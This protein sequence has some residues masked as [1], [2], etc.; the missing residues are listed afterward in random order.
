MCPDVCFFPKGKKNTED[1]SYLQRDFWEKSNTWLQGNT[2]L[3]SSYQWC[4]GLCTSGG[5]LVISTDTISWLTM[6]ANSV[7]Q[8]FTPDSFTWSV[9]VIITG[10]V[11][12][13]QEH[14]NVIWFKWCIHIFVFRRKISTQ[15]GLE[16][17]VMLIFTAFT[18]TGACCFRSV[19]F[20]TTWL[21]VSVW[22]LAS[23]KLT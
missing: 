16:T 15:I 14:D 10:S 7:V 20:P 2:F 11:F 13:P 5:R 22:K 21:S 19:S 8:Y 3:L 4:A 9:D 12:V 6:L 18:V 23:N 17:V 1:L